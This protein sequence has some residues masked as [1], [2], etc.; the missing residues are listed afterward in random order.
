[1]IIVDGQVSDS[2]S[3]Q[4]N[5]VYDRIIYV[6]PIDNP[7]FNPSVI[8]KLPFHSH[9]LEVWKKKYPEPYQRWL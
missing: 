3:A 4:L 6:D 2:L 7:N 9:Q 1:V 5:S 8:E